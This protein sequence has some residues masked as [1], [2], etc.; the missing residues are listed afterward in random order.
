MSKLFVIDHALVQNKMAML[1]DKDLGTKGFR[2]LLNEITM[3]LGYEVT[4]KLYVEE[5]ASETPLVKAT[6]KVMAGKKLATAP[7]LRASLG[8]VDDM[9]LLMPTSKVGH[10][11]MFRD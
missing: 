2:E 7:I 1:R 5:M 11:G 8:M 4:G 3:F 9:L 10:I 6:Q